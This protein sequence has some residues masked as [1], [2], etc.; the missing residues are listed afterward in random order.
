M[1]TLD[2][3]E[4]GYW[5]G[6]TT[7]PGNLGY[8]GWAHTNKGDN[9]SYDTWISNDPFDAPDETEKNTP[10]QSTS[11]GGGFGITDAIQDGVFVATI[12]LI[13]VLALLPLSP[14]WCFLSKNKIKEA[15]RSGNQPH[16][17][18]IVANKIAKFVCVLQIISLVVA[19][20][21]GIAQL[22]LFIPQ[23]AA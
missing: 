7:V 1:A 3:Y 23:L 8:S 13:L 4:N 9:N 12:A 16:K 11:G 2:H 19:I 14:V 20:L 10:V 21:L 15:I 17:L 5:V 6:S 18:L 22:V